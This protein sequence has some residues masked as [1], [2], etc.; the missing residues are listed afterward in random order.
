MGFTLILTVL[1]QGLL[2]TQVEV[3]KRSLATG[4][5]FLLNL[6]VNAVVV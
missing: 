2:Y 3:N 6:P 4:Y 5:E 1:S